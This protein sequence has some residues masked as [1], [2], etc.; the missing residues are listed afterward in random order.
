MPDFISSLV[1]WRRENAVAL[2]QHIERTTGRHW[3]RALAS[4]WDVSE[5]TLYGRFAQDVLGRAEAVRLV[6]PL[7][8]DYYKR[9][10]LTVPELTTF[11][12]RVDEEAIAV[13]LTSKAGMKPDDYV[14]V[15]ERQWASPVP[16]ERV[17]A[18]AAARAQV[19]PGGSA[20]VGQREACDGEPGRLVRATQALG[21]GAGT[22]RDHRGRR[23][24]ARAG[25]GPVRAGP[26]LTRAS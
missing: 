15:L 20:R 7:C 26:R 24:P 23:R 10:P 13:S 8:L 22:L 21:Q 14:E 4:A 17:G 18:T 9:V 1:P 16:H 25:D 6:A 11:L 12:D 5:Y 19:R 3:L 2:L